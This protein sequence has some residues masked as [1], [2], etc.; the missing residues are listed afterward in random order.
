M[1]NTTHKLKI[2]SLPAKRPNS[3][4]VRFGNNPNTPITCVPY[5]VIK[6]YNPHTCMLEVEIWWLKTRNLI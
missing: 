2:Q 6:S 4:M 5:S 3:W 1:A